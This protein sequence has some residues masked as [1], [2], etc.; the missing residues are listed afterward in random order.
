LEFRDFLVD[1]ER[2]A[3]WDVVC[4]PSEQLVDD[5]RIYGNSHGHPKTI[6]PSRSF[7]SDYVLDEL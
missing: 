2:I 4:C 5:N 6:T 7:V 3:F 1:L